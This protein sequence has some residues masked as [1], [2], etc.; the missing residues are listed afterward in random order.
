MN[1]KISSKIDDEV[2]SYRKDRIPA[3]KL[4][5]IEYQSLATQ[6]KELRDKLMEIET[7]AKKRFQEIYS[8]DS[9]YRKTLGSKIEKEI[10]GDIKENMKKYSGYGV[11]FDFDPNYILDRFNNIRP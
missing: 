10:A 5:D 2:S 7:L 1:G 9:Q 8:E 6:A 3:I 4:C 11:R